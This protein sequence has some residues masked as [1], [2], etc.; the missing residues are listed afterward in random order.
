MDKIFLRE[1]GSNGEGDGE[2]SGWLEIFVSQN[3]IFV[4]DSHLHNEIER[5]TINS[6]LYLSTNK[7]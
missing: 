3:S 1:F 6:H 5:L 2:F 4:T 7:D